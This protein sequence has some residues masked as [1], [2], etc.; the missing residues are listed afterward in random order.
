MVGV[1]AY[2]IGP[3][4]SEGVQE[5]NPNYMFATAFFFESEITTNLG[6]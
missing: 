6:Q 4:G 5:K 2:S 3:R 1:E